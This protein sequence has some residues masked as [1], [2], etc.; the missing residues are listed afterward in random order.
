MLKDINL[1]PKGHYCGSSTFQCPYWELKI[2]KPFRR[3][4]Y[5]HW[6]EK[7]DWEVGT[8]SYDSLLW[9]RV[10]ECGINY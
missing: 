10:K 3:N 7:G 9:D 8:E 2:E 6:L 4:G 5:C 1:I